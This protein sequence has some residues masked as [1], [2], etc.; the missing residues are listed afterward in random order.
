[1]RA[2]VLPATAVVLVAAVLGIQLAAGAASY[3][4]RQPADPC[5][6]RPIPAT[7]SGLDPLLEEIVLLGLDNAACQLGISRERLVLSLATPQT[8]DPA[9][10]AALKAGLRSAVDRLERA[11][12][13][14]KVSQLLPDA[15]QRANLPGI[16][17]T[18]IGLVPDSVIDG[19]LPTG[20]LLLRTI[21]KLDVSALLRELRDPS[22]LQSSVESALLNAALG[23]IV[24]QLRPF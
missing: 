15:L 10:P 2:L 20:P 24:A 14:P 13:L 6:A 7:L 3:G 8:M 4:P 19:T 23:E 9:A 18:A 12:R 1:M 21:D 11:G 16:V 5:H 22:R 17:K